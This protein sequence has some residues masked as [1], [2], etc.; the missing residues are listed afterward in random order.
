M[1]AG[2]GKSRQTSWSEFQFEPGNI[3]PQ[4]LHRS[5]KR[6][7]CAVI[8]SERSSKVIQVLQ[9][10]LEKLEQDAELQPDDHALRELRTHIALNDCR[11][12]IAVWRCSLGT[13]AAW[14]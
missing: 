3:S 2:T 12:G 13:D 8:V 1:I 10:T 14:R 5:G 9:S 4:F 7:V 11:T 6:G